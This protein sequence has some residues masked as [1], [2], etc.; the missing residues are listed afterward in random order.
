MISAALAFEDII[1]EKDPKRLRVI[2][3]TLGYNV[4]PV[5]LLG[6]SGWNSEK[7]CRYLG[8]TVENA[9]FPDAF[10]SGA[11]DRLAVQFLRSFEKKYGRTPSRI[12]R[13]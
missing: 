7:L 11:E 5:T 12:L 4:Q 10:F 1:V 2:R 9:I 6:T 13:L 3:R 8:R